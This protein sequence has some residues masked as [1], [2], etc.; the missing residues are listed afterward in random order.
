MALGALLLIGVF[1]YWPVARI[2]ALGLS[3][4]DEVSFPWTRLLEVA[5]FTV[6]QAAVSA[7]GSVAIGLVFAY[8]LFRRIGPAWWL[9]RAAVL[10]P[11]TLPVIVLAIGMHTF[12]IE[13]VLSG[14]TLIIATHILINASVATRLLGSA[15]QSLDSHTEDAAA[16]DGAG[17]WRTFRSVSLPQL[18]P[19]VAAS[20]LLTFA[21]SASSFGVVLLLGDVGTDTLETLI[22]KVTTGY[23]DLR[24]AA[25]LALVQ[26]AIVGLTF[27]LGRGWRQLQLSPD[28]EQRQRRL[29]RRDSPVA[30]VGLLLG[31]LAA[32]P[33][34]SI[35]VQAFWDGSAWSL[36]NFANLASN[37]ERQL[38][39]A[40]VWQA[41]GNSA[42]N[43][44]LVAVAAT[45]LGTAT[46]Y[47]AA[48]TRNLWL[49]NMLN[50]AYTLP[51][52]VSTVVLGFGYLITFDTEPLAL[53][54][55]WLVV[56]VAQTLLALPLVVNLMTN[57]FAGMSRELLEA[58][59]SEGANTWQRLRWVELPL[60]APAIGTAAAFSA[61]VALGDFGASSFLAYGDQE[62]LPQV[63]F[64]LM[65]RPGPTN[66]G[67]A[68]AA[69]VV[70]TLLITA[71]MALAGLR[72]PLAKAD[73]R[74]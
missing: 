8:L 71:V 65:S 56:P 39:N 67:M 74:I 43:A 58:A 38:L 2:V 64:R 9:W 54:E 26:L 68:M 13:N 35:A 1:F 69:A 60:V 17:R 59:S 41:L 25:W 19:S 47:L 42:R 52:A 21:F 30:A 22:Y 62:T 34:A 55:T 23:L 12:Q 4:T 10:V 7:L 50:L 70:L 15:W 27:G 46:A 16:L 20:A 3:G 14:T 11:F 49:G 18:L 29:D 44:G 63:L 6:W 31:L 73:R 5:W 61:A 72:K 32:A 33:L 57:A 28:A 37:G 66:F 24:G 48:R 45:T 40:S 53:R 36:Q 51:L